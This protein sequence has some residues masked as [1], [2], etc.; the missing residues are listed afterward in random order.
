MTMSRRWFTSFAS[1]RAERPQVRLARSSYFE[2]LESRSLLATIAW[3][4]DGN[5]L[6]Q[7]WIEGGAVEGCE[8]AED[9]NPVPFPWRV[10]DGVLTGASVGNEPAHRQCS[11]LETPTFQFLAGGTPKIEFD[12]A[13]TPLFFSEI[14]RDH[15][16]VRLLNVDTEQTLAVVL[17]LLAENLIVPANTELSDESQKVEH[18]LEDAEPGVNYRVR[19]LARDYDPQATIGR[20]RFDNLTLTSVMPGDDLPEVNEPPSALPDSYQLIQGEMLTVAAPG[21][22]ANDT[23]K[24]GDRLTATLIENPQHG[25]LLLG[26]DGSFVYTHD[27]SENLSDQFTYRTDD[28]RGGTDDVTVA[29]AI[30]KRGDFNG[31]GWVGSDDISLMCAALDAPDSS[32]QFD[33]TSD[34]L[35][36]QRDFEFMIE[37]ILQTSVGDA[38]LDGVFDSADLVLIFQAGEYEDETLDNSSWAEGDWDCDGDFT[39]ADL[40]KA[41]QRGKYQA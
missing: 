21:V 11:W 5:D 19:F 41:F 34:N 26:E 40:V 31:D 4:F 29:I 3:T 12:V 2:T 27:G 39:S 10:E 32:K 37:E 6:P 20:I 30:E 16:L 9:G 18:E 38:N 13:Y 33:L 36:D 24:N 22:L 7:G 15:I 35:V 17:D 23:D 8:E 14:A 25:T 28:G 1:G